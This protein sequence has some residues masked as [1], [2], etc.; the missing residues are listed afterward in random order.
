MRENLYTIEPVANGF[1]VTLPFIHLGQFQGL[2]EATQQLKAMDGG[3][4]PV[5]KEVK[6]NVHVFTELDEAISFMKLH[7]SGDIN[8]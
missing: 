6:S 5:E 4:P 8:E 1:I 3:L 2:I 7:L